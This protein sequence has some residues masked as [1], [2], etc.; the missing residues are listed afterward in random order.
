M[1]PKELPMPGYRVL[2]ADTRHAKIFGMETHKSPLRFMDAIGNPYTGKHERDL[3]SDAPGRLM[4][5]SGGSARSTALTPRSTQKQHAATQFAR[6]LAR[7]LSSEARADKDA[8][9]VVVAAPRFI[10]ELQAHLSQATRKRVIRELR[11]DL[12]DA[13]R[14]DLQRRIVAAVKPTGVPA[15]PRPRR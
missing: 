5:R 6:L 14:L 9:L 15:T 7:R 12:V 13:P 3:V 10:A 1:N 11:R 4:T 2:V 8:A